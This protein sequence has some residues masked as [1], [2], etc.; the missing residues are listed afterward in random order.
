MGEGEHVYEGLGFALRPGPSKWTTIRLNRFVP[1]HIFLVLS[2]GDYDVS[3]QRDS[4]LPSSIVAPLKVYESKYILLIGPT[5]LVIHKI[6][7]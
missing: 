5:F 2:T 4:D 7:P 6:L 1:F 3:V